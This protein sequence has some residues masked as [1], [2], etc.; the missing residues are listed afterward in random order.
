MKARF[1][2]R[3]YPKPH[4]IEP[5]AKAFG[6]SRVVWNDALAIYQEAAKNKEPLPSYVDK[7]VITQAKKTEQRAWLAEVSN[8]VLQQSFRDLQTAWSN[9]FSSLKGKR[10]GKKVGRPKFKKKQSRQ[11]IRFRVGGFS[12]HSQ[13]VKLAKIGHIPMEVSR[14]LP[15]EP[16]SVTII[17]DTT[18][19]YFASFV[20]EVQP[21]KAIETKNSIGID[22]GLTHFAI[23]SNGE[24][25]ENP[26]IHQL[27]LK[28]IKRAN[29]KLSKC[30][31]GSNRREVA[32]LKLAKIHA[33]AKDSRTDFL[34][35]LT[36]KLACENQAL[37][38]ED[39]NV[40]GLVKN[41]KLS[42]AISDA[43]WY[44]FR[45]LLTAKCDKYDRHL[46][47]INRWEATSQ[48]CSACGFHGGKKELHVREWECLSCGTKHDRDIN[49]A[50]NIKVEAGFGEVS[51][52]KVL[53]AVAGGLSETQN[54]CRS[55]CKT[56]SVAVRVEASTTCKKESPRL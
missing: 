46:V 28:R 50:N 20:V 18:G 11:A 52:P 40:S 4:Q 53:P 6:C 23:L 2:Y 24:K 15:S 45:Q 37:A 56:T 30:S 39:L 13:S 31:K 47:V 12:V 21:F 17:K 38:I 34:H 7:Q 22:L 32:K 33:K 55:E 29:R 5:L 42:R 41:R 3:I 27:L 51:S 26:R 8:I 36:T 43:G 19:R 25:I 1:K 35:K 44:S 48:K 10:K 14:A 54:G 9:Y 49:A 16:S